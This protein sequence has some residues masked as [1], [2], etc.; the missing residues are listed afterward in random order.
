MQF[1]HDAVR[2][3]LATFVAVGVMAQEPTKPSIS[4]VAVLP[5]EPPA[6]SGN[7]AV[8]RAGYLEKD[9]KTDITQAEIWKM[10]S[11]YLRDGYVVTIYPQTKRGTF[12][13]LE[14]PSKSTTAPKRP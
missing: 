13:N 6:P 2:C 7:C 10:I 12:V 8:S 1:I 5:S 11:A 9:G 3:G 4:S 14:C